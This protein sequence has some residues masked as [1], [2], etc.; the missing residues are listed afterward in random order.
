M[1]TAN[2][3]PLSNGKE[4]AQELGGLFMLR[5]AGSEGR[6][7]DSLV[8]GRPLRRRFCDGAVMLPSPEG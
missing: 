2:L 3:S 6:W 7:P 5:Y 4:A 8:P 1:G